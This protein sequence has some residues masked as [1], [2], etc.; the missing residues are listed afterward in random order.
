MNM[1]R[2]TRTVVGLLTSLAGNICLLA[3]DADP[4]G[5]AAAV[6]ASDQPFD[7]YTLYTDTAFRDKM[8]HR[9]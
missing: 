6:T 7:L 5:L 4:S 1:I 9:P 3:S 8:P 2:I